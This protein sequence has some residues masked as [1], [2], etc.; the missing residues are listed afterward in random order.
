MNQKITEEELK[1]YEELIDIGNDE[2][3]PDQ[4]KLNKLLGHKNKF[5]FFKKKKLGKMLI[6]IIIPL[7]IV[8]IVVYILIKNIFS[9]KATFKLIKVKSKKEIIEKAGDIIIE[10]IHKNLNP[11][12]SL[13]T[14][15]LPKN[16]Y[17]Y[18][19]DKYEDNEI[20]FINTTFFNLY[21]YCGLEKNSKK[22]NS[23]Y[24]QD[25]LLDHID[26]NESNV[27][28]IQ[29]YGQSCEENAVK[30]KEIIENNDIDLQILNIED[31][32]NLGINYPGIALES[33]THIVQLDQNRKNEI[34]NMF[35]EEIK[36]VPSEGITQGIDDI[37]K[38]KNIL[39]VAKGKENAEGLRNLM[40]GS[41]DINKPISSLKNH[42]GIVYIV[43]DV[44]ACSLL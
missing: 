43:A 41:V 39:V 4:D 10:I 40:K 33:K 21:E 3:Q 35:G 20:S 37:I 28:F 8:I 7:I 14:G 15:G 24:I 16:I 27:C 34:A 25:N 17:K 42:V 26:I 30:Y 36:D 38:S 22:S 11:K 13:S 12:I 1:N 6:N 23:Y 18:L 19:I 44:D 2:N 32:N 31:N 5:S 29:S 9:Y